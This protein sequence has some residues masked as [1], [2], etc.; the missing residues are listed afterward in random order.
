[1]IFDIASSSAQSF[2][3][4]HRLFS[5]P[6]RFSFFVALGK[7]T[8][9]PFQSFLTPPS[10]LGLNLFSCSSFFI[11]NELILSKPVVPADVGNI[12]E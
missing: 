3:V 8:L 6:A 2:M 5:I 7:V 9:A 1:M 10:S 12:A 4:L 11:C